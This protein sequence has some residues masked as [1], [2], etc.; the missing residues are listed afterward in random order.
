[1]LMTSKMM[2]SRVLL[3]AVFFIYATKVTSNPIF[4]G[5]EPDTQ[6]YSESDSVNLD[7]CIR[8]SV[9][10]L[11]DAQQLQLREAMTNQT[12]LDVL[13]RFKNGENDAILTSVM[14]TPIVT[15]TPPQKRQILQSCHELF[16]RTPSEKI[17]GHFQHARRV[18]NLNDVDD[19]IIEQ[20][21]FDGVRVCPPVRAYKSLVIALDENNHPVQIVQVSLRPGSSEFT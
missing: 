14:Q 11:D 7:S 12:F 1:M 19:G 3:T 16:A 20:R 8:A 2:V 4:S 17:Q 13:E 10:P 15:F 6:E 9:T 21:G 5:R 18:S